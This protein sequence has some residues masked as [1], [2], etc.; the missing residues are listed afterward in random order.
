M[1]FPLKGAAVF[2]CFPLLSAVVRCFPLIFWGTFGKQSD[3]NK[4]TAEN[5]AFQRKT[6]EETA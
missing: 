2:R 3:Q 6:A 1:S 5:S 4:K